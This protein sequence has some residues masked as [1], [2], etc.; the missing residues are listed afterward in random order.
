[1]RP[2]RPEVTDTGER[3]HHHMITTRQELQ[4]KGAVWIICS[5][6]RGRQSCLD[7]KVISPLRLFCQELMELKEESL[8]FLD[9]LQSG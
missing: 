7:G 3:K 4:G 9:S 2:E 5:V 8:A 1:M 6:E